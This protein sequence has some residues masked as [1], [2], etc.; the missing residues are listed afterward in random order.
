MRAVAAAFSGALVVA[1]MTAGPA[2]A[3]GFDLISVSRTSRD[4]DRIVLGVVSDRA[5]TA[6]YTYA[7]RVERVSKGP[8][9]PDRWL[10]RDAGVSDCGMP[11]LAIG[12]RVVLEYYDPGRITDGP[13]FYAWKI[14]GD[15][16]VAFS[17]S[18]KPPLPKTLEQLLAWYSAAGLP[19]DTSTEL[20][21]APPSGAVL[22][23]I[24]AGLLGWVA[25]WRRWRSAR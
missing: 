4:A 2:A 16:T 10:I 5:G 11:I 9:L 21:V 8:S 19:P 13:W 22:V 12:E 17:D 1:I 20:P 14:N 3:C 7:I 25:S 18:H 6:V 24:A 15:G 23:L